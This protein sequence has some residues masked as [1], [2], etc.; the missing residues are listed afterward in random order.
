MVPFLR[1]L[2]ADASPGPPLIDNNTVFYTVFGAVLLAV[3]LLLLWLRR[4]A[5]RKG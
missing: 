2:V 4:A 1:D 5:G 3:L